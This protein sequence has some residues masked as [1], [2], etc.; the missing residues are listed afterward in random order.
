MY[1]A[2]MDTLAERALYAREVARLSQGQVAS[3]SGI[4]QQAYALIEAGKTKHPRT[5]ALVAEALGVTELWLMHGAGPMTT[6]DDT[7]PLDLHTKE[8][9][10]FY[11]TSSY[12]ALVDS[13]KANHGYDPGNYV[14]ITHLSVG[15]DAFTGDSQTVD[16]LIEELDPLLFSK[17]WLLKK[18]NGLNGLKKLVC[19]RA[20]G[21]SMEPTINDNDV[22]LVDTSITT[23]TKDEEIYVVRYSGMFRVKRVQHNVGFRLKLLSD[24]DHHDTIEVDPVSQED[25]AIIG[26]VI[27]SGGNI[28]A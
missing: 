17:K 14:A 6:D 1:D 11:D 15:A 20:K 8:K 2:D 21:K 7:I 19:L 13:F 3:R 9:S 18:V 4:S 24:N 16:F 12:N 28:N 27:W 10:E 25:F 26:K 22:L 23:A 5:S